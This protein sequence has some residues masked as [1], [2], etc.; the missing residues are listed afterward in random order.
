MGRTSQNE[1]FHVWFI[2]GDEVLG[3]ELAN[4][5]HIVVALFFTNTRK[6][7]SGLTTTTVLFGQLH[8]HPLQNFFVVALE[9]GVEHTVTIDNHEAEL[10]VVV[11]NFA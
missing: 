5:A 9:G 4:F 10:L 3:G 7:K 6:T 8:V 11:K 2:I 1:T